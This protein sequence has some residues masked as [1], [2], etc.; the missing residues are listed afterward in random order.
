M[1][2]ELAGQMIPAGVDVTEPRP[3]MVTLTVSWSLLNVAVTDLFD[4]SVTLQAPVP[5]HAPP[6]P[7]NVYPVAGVAESETAVL[8]ATFMLQEVPGHV[9]PAGLEVTVPEPVTDAV[10]VSVVV[11]NCAVTDWFEVAVRLQVPVPLQ[12][13]PHPRNV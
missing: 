5:P 2:H 10:S 1:L 11:A 8:Y 4:V 12:A 7:A 13:P 6:Q 3:V 9:M